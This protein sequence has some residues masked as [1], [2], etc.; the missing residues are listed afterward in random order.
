VEEYVSAG[1]VAQILGLSRQ[2]VD[3][4]TYTGRLHP[5]TVR[6]PQGTF[7]AYK[8]S[9]VRRLKRQRGR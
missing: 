8:L 7:R 3:R 5:I 2:S 4:L 6:T 1:V 9:D